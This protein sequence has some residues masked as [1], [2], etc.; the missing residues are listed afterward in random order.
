MRTGLIASTVLATAAIVAT[1]QYRHHRA[2]PDPAGLTADSK[3]SV[4]VHSDYVWIF[5]KAYPTVQVQI[6]F[7]KVEANYCSYGDRL[8]KSGTV[9]GK[10]L[11]YDEFVL[12]LQQG[13]FFPELAGAGVRSDSTN[14]TPNYVPR[15]VADM[16]T[17]KN[18]FF[19]LEQGR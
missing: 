13:F 15:F 9:P 17:E 11:S 19:A 1:V 3:S 16:R 14:R 2:Y 18:R 7:S 5:G 10:P 6:W 12:A 8:Y 4:E